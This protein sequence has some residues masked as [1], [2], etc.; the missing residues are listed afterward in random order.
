MF[1]VAVVFSFILL[2]GLAW[3]ASSLRVRDNWT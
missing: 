1:Y 3:G 2:L